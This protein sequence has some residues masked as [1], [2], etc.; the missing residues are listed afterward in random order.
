MKTLL[1]FFFRSVR[2]IL[3]P[4]VL[5]VDRLT[6]PAG[7]K[8]PPAEQ[9]RIDAELTAL[10]LYHFPSCPFCIKTRR[11]LKRLSLA[12][13]LRDVQHDAAHRETLR[14]GGGKAQVPCLSIRTADGETRWLYESRDIIAYLKERYG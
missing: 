9:A 8:R 5:V 1:R 13:E 4:L 7:V 6:T 3:T 10:A 14:A 11:A 2:A 12:I